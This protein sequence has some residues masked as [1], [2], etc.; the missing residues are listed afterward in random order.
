MP[1][2]SAK[3]GLDAA[4]ELFEHWRF[5]GVKEEE[6]RRRRGEVEIERVLFKNVDGRQVCGGGVFVVLSEPVGYVLAGDHGEVWVELDADDPAKVEFA[7]DE[8][9]ASLPCTDVDEGIAGDGVRRDCL[10]PAVDERA[11]DAGGYAVVCGYVFVVGV[12]GDEVFCG[13]EAAGIDAVEVVE[14][15][16]WKRG[17]LEAVARPGWRRDEGQLLRIRFLPGC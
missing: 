1:G 11:Q 5:E 2:W 15:V 14:R 3:L 8:H 6:Q 10:A 12:A 16:D 13:H 17:E 9:T 4:Q 7:G